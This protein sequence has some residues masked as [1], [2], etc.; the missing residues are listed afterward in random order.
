MQ[1]TPEGARRRAV[2]APGKRA[3]QCAWVGKRRRPYPIPPPPGEPGRDPGDVY[4][5][6]ESICDAYLVLLPESS[7]ARPTVVAPGSDERAIAES[8]WASVSV[9]AG[10]GVDE[11]PEQ[12]AIESSTSRAAKRM[13]FVM[14]WPPRARRVT[15]PHARHRPRFRWRGAAPRARHEIG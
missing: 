4:R 15:G 9:L 7:S 5:L 10:L 8:R 3:P 2:A 6:N 1:R 11:C 14:V 13:R 12:P